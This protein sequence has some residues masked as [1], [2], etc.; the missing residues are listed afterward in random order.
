MSHPLFPGQQ[1]DEK[2]HLITRQHVFVL[3][4][5]LAVWLLFVALLILFDNFALTAFP[6]L[7]K[8]PAVQIVNLFKTI[9]L[10]FLVAAAFS[11]WILYYLNVQIVTNE[12]VVDITQKNLLFHTTSELNLAR[13]QDVTAEIKGVFGT[14]FNFGN[15]YVQTAGETA[16]F[17]FDNVADPHHVAKIILDLYEALP[18]EEKIKPE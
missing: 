3:F 18:P 7:Q 16:R 14:F 5:Q 10:M 6:N 17:Q 13:I 8:D 4:K 2:I 11:V 1:P 9:Y 15:V 12:R